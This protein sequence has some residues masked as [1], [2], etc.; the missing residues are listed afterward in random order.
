MSAVSA[1]SSS[2]LV[3]GLRCVER[4]GALLPRAQ[5]PAGPPLGHAERGNHLLHAGAAAGGAHQFPRAAPARISLSS[6]RSDTA[7]RSR[8]FP[9]SSSLK[10][11]TWAPFS[12]PYS[13][14]QRW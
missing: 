5:N 2:G 4:L 11:L 9:A 14:R 6:V 7:R 12:P 3:G 13:D 1:A 10:R 8:V